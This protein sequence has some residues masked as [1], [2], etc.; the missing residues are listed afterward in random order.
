M[1]IDIAAYI[2]GPLNHYGIYEG[3]PEIEVVTAAPAE[4]VEAAL[5]A[6]GRRWM[7]VTDSGHELS[8]TG[9][10]DEEKERLRT[11]HG[12]DDLPYTPN[13]WGG[14]SPGERGL[15]TYVDCKGAVPLAM[16][17]KMLWVLREEL[18]NAGIKD[19]DVVAP[20]PVESGQQPV[21]LRIYPVK[22]PPG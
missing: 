18:A 11:E 5:M 13:Y 22:L 17:E 7:R 8:A 15:T 12:L 9:D 16:A 6:T 14:V 19:A 20:A 21:E 3:D 10:P 4:A 1:P 2:F